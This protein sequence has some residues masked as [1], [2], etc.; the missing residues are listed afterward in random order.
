MLLFQY[1]VKYIFRSVQVFQFW[2]F[3]KYFFKPNSTRMFEKSSNNLNVWKKFSFSKKEWHT[4]SMSLS[5]QR[6]LN[7]HYFDSVFNFLCIMTTSLCSNTDIRNGSFVCV[8]QLYLPLILL[9]GGE[10][11]LLSF[12]STLLL[13]QPAPFYKK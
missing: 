13:P 9:S 8:C 3:Y 7:P 6:L 2:A 1:T 5:C 4:L 12:A 11:L 10:G